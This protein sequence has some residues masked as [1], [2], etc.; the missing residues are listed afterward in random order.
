MKAT[1]TKLDNFL[2]SVASQVA[3]VKNIFIGEMGKEISDISEATH[4]LK[5]EGFSVTMDLKKTF[6]SLDE[7]FSHVCSQKRLFCRKLND[8]DWNWNK[9]PRTR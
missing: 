3:Y 4:L 6:D 2:S 8:L 1:T 5:M 9:K 7:F